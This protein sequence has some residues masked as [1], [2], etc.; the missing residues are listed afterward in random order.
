MVFFVP[1]P[2]NEPSYGRESSHVSVRDSPS[3]LFIVADLDCASSLHLALKKHYRDLC[4][5]KLIEISIQ[6]AISKIQH[7][8]MDRNPN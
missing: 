3:H 8:S 1:L 6:L 7:G 4:V 2:N 5:P